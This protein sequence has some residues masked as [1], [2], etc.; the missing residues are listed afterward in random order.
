M[1]KKTNK[2]VVVEETVFIYVIPPTCFPFYQI[3]S[4]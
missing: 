2:T 3:L 4:I 1:Q